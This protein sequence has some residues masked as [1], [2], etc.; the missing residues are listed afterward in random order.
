MCVTFREAALSK[1]KLYAG[2][3]RRGDRYV[4]LIAYQNK[5]TTD[6]PN[7]MILPLPASV[8]PGPENVVDT[9]GFKRFL[10]DMHHAT[11][12]KS[13]GVALG[14][15]RG[16]QTF[17]VGSYTVVLATSPSAVP[18]ALAGAPTNKR[19]AVNARVLDAFEELY[20]GW[21]LAVCCWD[22]SFKAEPLLW[23][24]EPRISDQLFAPALDAHDGQAPRARAMVQMDHHLAFGSTLHPTGETVHY[25][26]DVQVAWAERRVPSWLAPYEKGPLDEPPPPGPVASTGLLPP[27]VRGTRLTGRMPNGDFWLSTTALEGR[28]VRRAPGAAKGVPVSLDGWEG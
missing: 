10:D 21:P 6:G 12:L 28:A 7:A 22:G 11:E 5:A 14:A 3:A 26:D 17:D 23:W 1:T 20:P 27:H 15:P 18:E 13:R 16:V 25:Q 24:Y 4:H 19:P 8:M 9:R 2:E